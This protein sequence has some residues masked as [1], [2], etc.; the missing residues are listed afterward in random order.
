[1]K[2]LSL[3]TPVDSPHEKEYTEEKVRVIRQGYKCPRG[4]KRE[5][6]IV[7][8]LARHGT[9]GEISVTVPR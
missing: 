7:L 1:M 2:R 3:V 6:F 5:R 8:V 9:S 4:T